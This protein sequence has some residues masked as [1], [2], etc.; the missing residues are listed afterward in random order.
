MVIHDRGYSRWK[1]D[2]SRPVA[3][4]GVILRAG[5]RRAMATFFRRTLGRCLACEGKRGIAAD[6]RQSIKN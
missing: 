5:L 2:R 4:I 3:A 6:D 1:G